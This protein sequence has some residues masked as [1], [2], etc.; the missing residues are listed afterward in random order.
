MV[1]S[2]PDLEARARSLERS[3]GSRPTSLAALS[4]AIN[5][6]EVYMKALQIADTPGDRKRL[7][8]K[9]KELVNKAD[10]LKSCQEL[11]VK[12]STNVYPVSMRKLTTRENII[13]LEGSRL[14][15]YLFRPWDRPPLQS[16]FELKNG[17]D[18]FTDSSPL[19]L[20]QTQLESFGGWKRP[21]DAL[22]LIQITSGGRHLPNE[23]TVSHYDKVDLVQDLTCD[24]S[25]VASL[26]AGTS[27]FERGHA[28]VSSYSSTAPA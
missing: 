18:L 3:I 23:P 28:K 7:E 12:R 1:A 17:E 11:S 25:V 14:N 22:A 10:H 20:S 9:F 16:E 21:K 2:L 5:S 15:G 13:I 8:A 19:P 6:A 27:R 26:C 24:C 4:A